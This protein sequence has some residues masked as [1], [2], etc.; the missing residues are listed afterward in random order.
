[1]AGVS[2]VMRPYN[3]LSL[4]TP[5]TGSSAEALIEQRAIHA[6]DEAIGARAAHL[7]HAVFDVLYREQQLIRDA[8]GDA[9]ELPTVVGEDGADRH[10]E[11]VIEWQHAVVE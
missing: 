1:M 6:L 10:A 9:A 8:F 7:G 11:R 5:R 3:Q 2:R 4:M